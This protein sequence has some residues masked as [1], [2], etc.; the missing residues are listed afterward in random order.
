MARMGLA[1]QRGFT[2]RTQTD[3]A[4]VGVGLFICLKATGESSPEV[5][6]TKLVLSR[7]KRT[8]AARAPLDRIS[9]SESLNPFGNTFV[10]MKKLLI[11]VLMKVS[12]HSCIYT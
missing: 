10:L 8:L 12:A 7:S 9:N 2:G 11:M 5:G 6:K 4:P 1:R 3:C